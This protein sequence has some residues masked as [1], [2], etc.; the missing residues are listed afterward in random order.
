MKDPYDFDDL[1]I[2][3]ETEA[4]KRFRRI[5]KIVITIML[6]LMMLSFV[7]PFDVVFSLLESDKVKDNQIQAGDKVVMFRSEVL[8]NLKQFYIENQMTEIKMCLTGYVENE[9][10]RVTGFYA[11]ITHFK[12]PISIRSEACNDETIITMHTHPFRNCLFSYQ[13]IVSYTYYKRLNPKAITAIMC[14]LE[15]FAFY[16]G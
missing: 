3:E 9:E 10:Y 1:E 12:T 2:E 8:E 5:S 4:Q 11:P 13:D 14:D 6:I 15:R 16:S 7:I